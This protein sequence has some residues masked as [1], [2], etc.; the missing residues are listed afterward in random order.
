VV[1]S[2]HCLTTGG[3]GAAEPPLWLSPW[4]AHRVGVVEPGKRI[5]P[6]LSGQSKDLVGCTAHSWL[7]GRPN[8]ARWRFQFFKISLI[9]FDFRI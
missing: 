4:P 9:L 7:A 6:R 8:L 2:T 3:V 5:W 1:A